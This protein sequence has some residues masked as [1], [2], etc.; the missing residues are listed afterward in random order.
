ML[1][2]TIY[3]EG[4]KVPGFV[5]GP[6]V[7]KFQGTVNKEWIHISDWF[8]TIM[9]LAGGSIANLTLDGFDQWNAITGAGKSPRKVRLSVCLVYYDYHVSK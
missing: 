6:L 2:F 1:A 7:S 9:R 4:I 3:F 5:S 8:P